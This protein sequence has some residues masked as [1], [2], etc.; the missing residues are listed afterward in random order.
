MDFFSEVHAEGFDAWRFVRVYYC[1][2]KSFL[3]DFEER[4]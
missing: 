2:L 4:V 3:S 1:A